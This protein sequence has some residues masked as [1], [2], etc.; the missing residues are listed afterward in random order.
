MMPKFVNYGG[1]ADQTWNRGSLGSTL[2]TGSPGHQ[3]STVTRYM[4]RF[5]I[6]CNLIDFIQVETVR[7]LH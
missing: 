4:T 3:V 5:L 2:S 7:T 1:G 6:I